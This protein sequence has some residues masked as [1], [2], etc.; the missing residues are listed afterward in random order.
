MS[1]RD[2]RPRAARSHAA[3]AERR[4]R[5]RPRRD[6]ARS[7]A[8]RTATLAD[9]T[10]FADSWNRLELDTYMADGGRYR[11]R[12][13]AT[14]EAAPDGTISAQAASA[15]LPGARLQPAERRR[16]ALVRA[17]RSRAVGAGSSMQTILRVLPA[18]FDSARARDAPAGTIEVHQ[19]RIEARTGEQGRPTP[20]GLHRDGV[21]YVLVLLGRPAQH[22]QRRHDHPRARR[23]AARPLHAHRSVRRG[24]RRRHARRARRHA[25]R[26]DRSARSP[27]YRDVLVVTFRKNGTSGWIL[28]V[29]AAPNRSEIRTT[30]VRTLRLQPAPAIPSVSPVLYDPALNVRNSPL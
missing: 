25:G 1:T 14:Y 9:W 19:F 2:L 26:T 27:R 20:E 8:R 6:D 30:T 16:R 12:R 24:A 13:H 4:L 21:D 7:A 17:H 3:I 11:R 5:V 23:P 22:R 10:A 29:Q 15:A 18:L 28:D